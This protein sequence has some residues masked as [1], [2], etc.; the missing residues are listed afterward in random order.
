MRD[1]PR[2]K[3]ATAAL[4]HKEALQRAQNRSGQGVVEVDDNGDEVVLVDKM[5]KTMGRTKSKAL[6]ALAEMNVR[7]LEETTSVMKSFLEGFNED[8]VE[9]KEDNKKKMMFLQEASEMNKELLRKRERAVLAREKI[10]E[11]LS[12]QETRK[13]QQ[14]DLAILKEEP[15]SVTDEKRRNAIKKLQDSIIDYYN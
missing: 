13:K 14:S 7:P 5:G 10:A 12:S 2:W 6:K 3:S 15:D 4:E 1:K 8:K 9:K 11:T